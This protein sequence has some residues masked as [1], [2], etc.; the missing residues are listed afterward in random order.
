V[1]NPW[2]WITDARLTFTVKL[3]LAIV[4]GLYLAGLAV[5]FLQRIL[6]LVYILVGAVFLAYLVYPLVRRLRARMPLGFAIAC[7]YAAFALLVA[8]TLWLVVPGLT[9][10]IRALVANAPGA[11]AAFAAYVNDPN[12]PLLA[13]LP[14]DVRASL[15]RLPQTTIAWLQTHGLETAGH[16]FGVVRGVVTVVATFVIMPL[17]SAYLLAE[18][19]HL[20]ASLRRLV[21]S[22]KWDATQAFLAQI[23]GVVGGFIRGQLIVAATIGAI[24]TI[25]LLILGVPYAFLLG[26]FAAL[27]DLVPMVGAV[28]TFIPAV[29]IAFAAHGWVSAA[30]VA[31][32]FIT[33]FQLEGHVISPMI[34]SSQVKLSPL[35]VLIAVLIG[36]E[37]GGIFG[38]LVAVPIAGALRI[39]LLRVIS[40]EPAKERSS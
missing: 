17:L 31:V 26:L 5:E 21:P 18:A 40:Q 19:D 36:A 37:L 24:L 34:V 22:D 8:V 20:R 30:I 6:G 3:L 15:L 32:I 12:N 29:A 35:V 11:S 10:D 1:G 28:V 13:R 4:L 9:N 38:M 25:A 23:D 2:G 33:L 39:I 14:D 7:V 16:A 27:G